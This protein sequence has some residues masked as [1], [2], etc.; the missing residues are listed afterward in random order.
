MK[1]DI[2]MQK[3]LKS[4]ELKHRQRWTHRRLK[5]YQSQALHRLRNY[6]YARSPFYQQFHQGLYDR[7][8]E[9]L[10]VLTKATMMQHFDDLVTDRDVNRLEIE[11]Y[12]KQALEEEYLH[13]YWVTTTPGSTG[14]PGLFLFD[15][16]EWATVLASFVRAGNAIPRRAE[17][18]SAVIASSTPWHMSARI[19]KTIDKKRELCID[20]SEPIESIVEK[21][22][23]WQPEG[24]EAYASILYRLA[25]EQFA[26][27]LEIEPTYLLSTSEVLTQEMRQRIEKSWKAPLFN[28]YVAT[29]VGA[30]AAECHLHE[31]LHLFE[32][33]AIVEVVDEKNRPVPPGVYGDKLLLTVLFN[34]TQPL[35]RYELSDSLRL[36]IDSC[37]CDSPYPLIEDIQGR[38]EEVLH[39]PAKKGSQVKVHPHT[40]DRIL[41][42]MH[43][44]QW[45]IV[46]DIYGL[47][48]SL[49][50]PANEWIDEELVDRLRQELENQGAIVPSITVNHV[51]EFI[52]NNTGKAARIEVEIEHSKA[53]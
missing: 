46:R 48:V 34:Y 11:A 13:R 23:I 30:I 42:A 32:D 53:R 50:S 45:Q 18:T 9:E 10:P 6:A 17:M 16:V 40:F 5:A 19:S 51:S 8:L 2:L 44:S 33:L 14:S 41:D 52:R 28:Q 49:N 22:N 20:A 26:G 21:L 35:I 36:A 3:L 47:H 1:T 4:W 12:L 43:V 39:L 29:E 27:R 37:P 7:P 15:R 38:N 25:E 24:L 31:G